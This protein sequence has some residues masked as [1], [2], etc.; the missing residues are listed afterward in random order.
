M[1]RREILTAMGMAGVASS[2]P[3]ES[4]Q[5]QRAGGVYVL[6]HGAWH[7]G[8]CW[9]KVAERLRAAGCRVFTPTCTGLGDRAHLLSPEVGLATFIEDVVS[10]IETEEL[11]DVILVGHSFGGT[12]ISGAVDALPD[13][14]GHVVYL[15]AFLPKSGRSP[16]SLIPPDLVEARRKAAIEVPGLGGKT[17]ALPVPPPG[18][19]GVT[20]PSDVAWLTRHLRPHPIKTYEDVLV[21]AH[22]ALG[23]GRPKT[24]IACTIPQYATLDPT[25]QWVRSQP[26]WT[27]KELATGHDAMVTAPDELTDMLLRL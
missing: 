13:R 6:V 19:F 12:I 7:G 14:I 5:G 27:Y 3:G 9:K 17:L 15:D 20:D 10:T 21:L 24:F 8:W 16:F 23:A 18:V 1:N 22:P 25:H 4:A 11:N 26:D 2:V